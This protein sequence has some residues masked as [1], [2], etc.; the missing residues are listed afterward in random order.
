V[1]V[2]EEKYL[3]G[4]HKIRISAELFLTH[5]RDRYPQAGYD[6]VNLT[7]GNSPFKSGVPLWWWDERRAKR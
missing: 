3:F 4:F 6:F 2:A 7:G 5:S 1:A